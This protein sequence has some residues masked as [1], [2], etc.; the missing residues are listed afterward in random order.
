M[1]A[2]VDV[3]EYRGVW[4]FVEQTDGTPARVSFELLGKG[5]ELA[6]TLGVELTALVLGESLRLLSDVVVFD[7]YDG[8]FP[9]DR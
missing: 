9:F 6:D 5:R 7:A 1:P 3:N 8:T 2:K 4:V